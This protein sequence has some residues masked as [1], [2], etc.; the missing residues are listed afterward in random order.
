MSKQ[1]QP[2]FLFSSW[3]RPN[4][5]PSGVHSGAES[6]PSL[7][8]LYFCTRNGNQIRYKGNGLLGTRRK[9]HCI[10]VFRD[11]FLTPLVFCCPLY[12]FFPPTLFLNPYFWSPP[13]LVFSFEH[14]ILFPL[15][16]AFSPFCFFVF[17][18]FLPFRFFVNLSTEK[19]D[20]EVYI[21]STAELTGGDGSLL[22]SLKKSD[23]WTLLSH[24]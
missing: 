14:L 10:L 21:L 8:F 23:P 16:S 3:V 19:F 12:C 24:L 18:F 4:I 20:S 6:C 9:S 2:S 15:P 22:F 11:I 7:H 5:D 1:R 13:L 17:R